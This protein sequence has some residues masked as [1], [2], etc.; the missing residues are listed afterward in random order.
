MTR[1]LDDLRLER[2]L[3]GQSRRR[4]SLLT[5]L[6]S[7]PT[8]PSQTLRSSLTV[9]VGG[10]QLLQQRRHSIE[11]FSA[12]DKLPADVGQLARSGSSGSLSSGSTLLSVVLPRSKSAAA[13][14][15]VLDDEDVGCAICKDALV[16]RV[17]DTPRVQG[18]L[19]VMLFVALFLVDGAIAARADDAAFEGINAV[20][21][22]AAAL[23]GAE[24][25]A[26][27][28]ARD[29]YLFSFYFWFDLLGTL[30]ILADISWISEGL[31]IEGA[32]LRA[33]RLARIGARMARLT[34]VLRLL[35][36]MRYIGQLNRC[37]HFGGELKSAWGGKR[38][39]KEVEVEPSLIAETVSEE[40]SKQVAGLVLLV[41]FLVPSL[42]VYVEPSRGAAGFIAALEPLAAP[43]A[44]NAT[45]ALASC[46]RDVA[47]RFD[48]YANDDGSP[49]TLTLEGAGGECVPTSDVGAGL[50][51][52]EAVAEAL[53]LD[54]EVNSEQRATFVV[55]GTAAW[56]F[57]EAPNRRIYS[58]ELR[59][60]ALEGRASAGT[61]TGGVVVMADLTRV[62]VLE[63]EHNIG[64]VSF[65]LL[66]LVGGSTLLNG[67]V[68][69]MVLNP[70]ERILAQ[71]HESTAD[72]F[73]ALEVDDDPLSDNEEIA[74]LEVLVA[75]M[76]NLVKHVSPGGREGEGVVTGLLNDAGTDERSRQYLLEMSQTRG[77]AGS[78]SHAAHRMSKSATVART[79]F[80]RRATKFSAR[81]EAAVETL[82]HDMKSVRVSLPEGPGGF[83]EGATFDAEALSAPQLQAAAMQMF[84]NL[85]LL[86]G[87]DEAREGL[88]G[89]G[90]PSC[91][92]RPEALNALLAHLAAGYNDVSYHGFAH[93]VDVTHTVYRFLALTETVLELRPYE[94]LALMVAALAHDLGHPGVN[95]AFLVN[96]RH[97]LAT[98]YN[99]IS[100]LEMHHAARLYQ[101]LEQ[102]PEADVFADLDKGAWWDV[103]R[104]I[105]AA[106]QHTDMTKH[107]GMVSKLEVLHELRGPVRASSSGG[108]GEDDG[109]A[110]SEAYF[111]NEDE[112]AV[113]VHMLLHAADIS[114]PTRPRGIYEKWAKRVVGE[115]FAQ[116]DR[117]RAAG[118]PVSANCD[119]DTTNLSLSQG[120]SVA[121]C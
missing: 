49:V 72:V 116:G 111:A 119:R 58:Q 120:L 109:E 89:A 23:F 57:R 88:E 61:A 121:V 27:C 45:D 47:A 100:V 10:E 41:V 13:A 25:I 87:G 96:T 19:L 21:A 30:S 11:S 62:H 16:L 7:V 24:L 42:L 117:E 107:F 48:D 2:E 3:R 92:V 15:V 56:V 60:D 31:G 103:R 102:H 59:S 4:S 71:L 106:I 101:L 67:T 18:V 36:A 97:E 75:K 46:A 40:I 70:L 95:N 83:L 104:L 84:A 98:T 1:Q 105:I 5:G 34:R 43:P 9:P 85:G 68:R 113:V 6:L 79:T 81:S 17:L 14:E 99:D 115:F 63:A 93:V 90:D 50:A 44:A 73:A 53:A 52:A 118:L 51:D 8:S 80:G 112:R 78:L 39:S 86:A 29:G 65:V 32:V 26:N 74:G 114:N 108:G 91:Q 82:A 37:F 12:L 22:V 55:A 77:A 94:R 54:L 110:S 76:S 20:M 28:A 35:K 38:A 69:R 66:V 64:L 33:S